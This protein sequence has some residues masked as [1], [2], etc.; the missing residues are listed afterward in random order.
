[1]SKNKNSRG[2]EAEKP[3]EIPAKGWIDI[4][5]RTISQISDDNIQIV[6]AGVAF[7]FFMA[8]F[9]AILA[10][11]NIYSLVIEPATIREHFS[12]LSNILP[13]TAYDLITGI[14]EPLLKQPESTIGWSLLLSILISLW[15]ANK[16]TSALF[17]GINIAYDEKD[18]RGFIKKT[19]LTFIFTIGAILL[20]VLC[21]LVLVFYPA[22]I[23]R[24]NISQAME[25]FI[26]WIRWIV[27]AALFVFGMGMLYKKAPDRDDPETRWL[28]WGAVLSTVLW[29]AG[30]MLFSWYVD[31]FG[32]YDKVYGSFAA[33]IILL[34][35]LFISAFI[36][37]IGAEINSEMEHQTRR[38]TTIGEDKPM[39]KRNAYHADHVAGKDLKDEKTNPES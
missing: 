14:L 32:S 35:W 34:L 31:N 38:D 27:I 36:V 37:L 6:S 4:G 20:F 18:K 21:I 5:K 10:M 24:L 22:F 28:S 13:A 19:G 11:V 8:L 7:Y 2:H 39:G 16:G 30:S 25:S 9:P 26:G 12:V 3:S 17:E 1:M 29:L 33:V 15:S 23:D